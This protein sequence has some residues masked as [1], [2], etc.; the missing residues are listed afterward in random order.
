VGPGLARACRGQPSSGDGYCRELG[1]S[2]TAL[3]RFAP[4]FEEQFE[5][6]LEEGVPVFSFTFGLLPAKRI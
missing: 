6:V 1:I 4:D 5:A 3:E 2:R